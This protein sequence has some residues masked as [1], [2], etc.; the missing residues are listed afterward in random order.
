MMELI[1]SA[2][3]SH[4]PGKRNRK[5]SHKGLKY[6]KIL[7]Y[8]LPDKSSSTDPWIGMD[9]LINQNSKFAIYSV[10]LSE[11]TKKMLIVAAFSHNLSQKEIKYAAPMK[12]LTFISRSKTKKGV[13]KRPGAMA[14]DIRELAVRAAFKK[15]E[16]KG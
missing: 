10:G 9:N 16:Q 11:N 1:S 8:A 6:I 13:N 14:S 15:V 4:V 12:V 7:K 2:I 5:K 3:D